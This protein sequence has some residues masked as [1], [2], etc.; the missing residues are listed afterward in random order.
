MHEKFINFFK[1]VFFSKTLQN[2]CRSRKP[3]FWESEKCDEEI[4]IIEV[5]PATS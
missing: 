2:T 4:D 3:T 1:A 5:D